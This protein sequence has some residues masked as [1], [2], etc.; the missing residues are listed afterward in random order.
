MYLP[1][2]YLRSLAL[3]LRQFQARSSPPPPR[4]LS[5]ICHFFFNNV[6]N[7][8]WWGQLIRTNPYGG[9]SG[10]VQTPTQTAL[11]RVTD[12]QRSNLTDSI[13]QLSEKDRCDLKI[14]LL[15]LRPL[16]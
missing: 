13:I 12:D 9:A 7:A 2:L 1:L 5:G 14:K 6:A 3:W 15:K 8:P 4:H 10:R 16:S 11:S